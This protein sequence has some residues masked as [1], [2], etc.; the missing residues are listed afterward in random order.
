MIFSWIFPWIFPYIWMRYVHN[1]PCWMIIPISK[2]TLNRRQVGYGRSQAEWQQA[3]DLGR[4]L[5][6]VADV[7]VE[8]KTV[9][10]GRDTHLPVAPW[11]FPWFWW[12]WA[13]GVP[14][15]H[16][17]LGKSRGILG[18]DGDLSSRGG[19]RTPAAPR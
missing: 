19:K 10:R 3:P 6:T 13:V 17:E 14:E 2:I 15:K 9:G 5:A 7:A 1:F 11:R 4:V 16:G 12:I 18:W 8:Q